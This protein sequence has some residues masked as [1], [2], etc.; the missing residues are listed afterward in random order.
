MVVVMREPLPLD[1]GEHVRW[2]INHP[3]GAAIY[4]SQGYESLESDDRTVEMY[5]NTIIDHDLEIH[6]CI[7]VRWRP[8]LAMERTKEVWDANPEVRDHLFVSIMLLKRWPEC[9]E[10]EYR[11]RWMN[12]PHHPFD[13]DSPSQRDVL[14]AFMDFIEGAPSNPCTPVEARWCPRHGDCT[15]PQESGWEDLA[16]EGCPLHRMTSEHPLT[17]LSE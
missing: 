1:V 10:P 3:E 15:C 9:T 16:N 14:S 11:A 7:S 8:Y 6:Y 17:S 4:Q 2:W 5:V 13:D 12:H